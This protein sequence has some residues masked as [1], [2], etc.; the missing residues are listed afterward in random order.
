VSKYVGLQAE[1]LYARDSV[2]WACCRSCKSL[3]LPVLLNVANIVLQPVKIKGLSKSNIKIVP[4][5]Q[6]SDLS[7]IAAALKASLSPDAA[8]REPAQAALQSGCS[9]PGALM[10][11]LNL[12][13]IAGVEHDVAMA[14]AVLFKN[15]VKKRW[16]EGLTGVSDGE[17]QAIRQH[18]IG[19]ICSC[20]LHLQP[21]LREAMHRICC[22]DCHGAW[23]SAVEE[24]GARYAA[25]SF[26]NPETFIAPLHC[27]LLLA[28]AFQYKPEDQ[29]ALVEPLCAAIS[30]TLLLTLQQSLQQ[31]A[32]P[33]IA[34]IQL[35]I[36][37][38]FW[39]LTMFSLPNYFKSP[40]TLGV[41]LQAIL[42]IST[43]ETP[44]SVAAMEPEDAWRRCSHAPL[45]IFQMI[46]V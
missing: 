43:C 40:D 5:A 45:C 35:I 7:G 2:N 31:A 39:S 13:G 12:C 4:A 24:C 26:T 21:V 9:T 20:A 1:A 36:N 11:L 23:P 29:R 18:I 22:E 33:V 16:A 41:W 6:M 42:A 25:A 10:S 8:I 37:K 15:E 32:S 38:I 27:L 46:F 28:K 3:V 14:S 34:E 19:A 17:K 44:P 30:P